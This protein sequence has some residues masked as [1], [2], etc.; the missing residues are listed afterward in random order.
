MLSHAGRRLIGWPW[1]RGQ[2]NLDLQASFRPIAGLDRPAVEPNGALGDG[3][4]QA[5]PAGLTAAGVVNAI[6]GAEELV[7]LFL[8]HARSR[9]HDPD[10]GLRSPAALAALQHD[11]HDGAFPG[12]AG[13]VADNIFN[14]AV[15]Q[16]GHAQDDALFLD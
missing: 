4:P 7:Q 15:E 9:V 13:G 8:R 1:S 3:Q 2:P 12:V 6:E 16:D 10:Y 14:R 5:H 11:L